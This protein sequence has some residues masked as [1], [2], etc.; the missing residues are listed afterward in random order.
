MNRHLA[1]SAIVI[2]A[3]L[4]WAT[5]HVF[6]APKGDAITVTG[7]IVDLHCYLDH[8]AKG[9]GHKTCGITCA[10]AGN[11]IGLLSDKGEL[12]LLLGEKKHSTANDQLIEKMA[13]TVTITG[14]AVKKGGL[15]AIYF[16]A[17]K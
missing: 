2:A 5:L 13:S 11:P 17:V 15:Q 9:E 1:A 16:T 14:T 7:E 10:K 6:A 4:G 12:Y 8:E 3:I